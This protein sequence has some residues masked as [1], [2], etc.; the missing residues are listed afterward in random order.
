[1]E[2][3]DNAVP[4]LRLWW[5]GARPRTLPA[6]V[7]P[8]VLGSA[9]TAPWFAAAP[10]DRDRSFQWWVFACALGVALF[11]Q[12][13]TNY[14]NDYSDG[15]RGTDD[16]ATRS[17]PD[18]LV[19]SGLAS[20][21]TVKRMML[22]AFVATALCGAPLVVWVDWRVVFVGIAAIAAGWFY[23]G[24]PNPYGYAGYGEVFV[25]VFFGLVAT[26]GS[27]YVQTLTITWTAVLC[28]VA[29]GSLATALLVVNNLRDIRSDAASGKRTLAVKIGDRSTRILYTVL[30]VVPFLLVPAVVA[31]TSRP[32]AALAFIAVIVARKP[33]TA[34]LGGATGKD[35]VPVLGRT[36]IIQIVY[37]LTL[38]AGLLVQL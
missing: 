2:S 6:A 22:T 28:G 4:P 35:L 9:A 12:I 26:V 25:F 33:V 31:S 30:I 16:P 15:I 11:V 27:F 7:A 20:A 24:G 14:A 18:R 1:M 17:G 37:A 8:V 32:L 10:I 5:L 38:S 13:A 36:G 21:S 3:D 23:T 34:V 19:G 29:A